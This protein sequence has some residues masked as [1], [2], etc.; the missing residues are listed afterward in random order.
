MNIKLKLT[1]LSFLQFF[2]WGAWL[3][4]LASYGF[5][6]KQWSGKEFGIVFSTLGIGSLIMPPISGIIADKYF[7]LEK[8]YGIHHL[9]Y[10]VVLL[11]LPQINDPSAFFWVLLV[12]MLFYMPTIALSNSLSYAVLKKYDFDVVKVFPPIRVWGTI[13]FIAAMWCTNLFSNVNPPF[14]FGLNVANKISNF[15]GSAIQC[16]QFYYAAVFAFI[17]GLFS[18]TLPKIEPNKENS[19]N[20][21][22]SEML[23]LNAFKLFRSSKMAMF[24]IFSMLLGAALQLTNAYGETYIK[25]F[26]NFP[27]Y[28]ETFVVKSSN[29]IL[30]ISQ[31]SETVFILAIPFFLKRFGIKK[32]MLFS[33]IAW[34]L[35]FGFF[36]YGDPINSLWMIIFSNIV[37][38]FAFDF[39]NISGSLFIETTTDSK[40]RSSAQG[41]F[42]MMSNGIGAII[43]S[44]GSGFIIDNYCTLRF[45]KQSDLL[46]YLE[47]DVNNPIYKK[48]IGTNNVA[49]DVLTN[50]ISIKDWHIIWLY[51]AIY[52]LVIGV[53]FAVLFKHEHN[54]SLVDNATH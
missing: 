33:M 18:F 40:I 54:P 39:F 14:S 4:T 25:D 26:E 50:A 46:K 19:S 36:S 24:F 16:N 1:I 41:L 2:V 51:F 29:I 27:K 23:G 37:Y 32:V 35:R 42:M 53:F 17:L 49:N 13:G 34:V 15:T 48:I 21:S 45:T 8:L 30:S 7:N 6:F 28:A 10:G 9:L 38:G 20:K 12:G 43:G 31:I 5:G 11:I 22:L 52:A 44:L 47:T 3:T